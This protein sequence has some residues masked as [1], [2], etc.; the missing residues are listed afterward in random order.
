MSSL[1]TPACLFGTG[2]ASLSWGATRLPDTGFK[3]LGTALLVTAAALTASPALAD[4][5]VEAADG[6]RVDC[7]LSRDELTRIA[8]VGDEF[9]SVSKIATGYPYND[10]GV[11]HEPLRGDI[12]I[13]VPP[14]FAANSLSFFATSKQG[15]VYKFACRT[16]VIEAHQLFITNPAL[17]KP[18]AAEWENSANPDDTAI[19]L[20]K[21]MAEGVAPA[22]YAVRQKMAR[23][24]R[25]GAVEVQL[26][27]EYRGAALQGQQLLL[28]NRGRSS[29][30]LNETAL[31][32]KNTRAIS[33]GQNVLDPGQS[34][35]AFV[36]T[37]TRGD[38]R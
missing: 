25:T 2:L 10:F 9:S 23:P 19:A 29:I 4:Q 12:Y 14:S 28:T 20:I 26:I 36:V 37:S 30:T 22:G 27:A 7:T 8:L 5:F 18:K 11:T 34:T 21:A 17:A 32:P 1:F 15:F 38:E 13:S 35:S 31:A 3:A 6:A 16:E 33:L 24:V